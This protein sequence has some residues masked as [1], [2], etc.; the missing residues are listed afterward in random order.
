MQRIEIVRE[1]PPMQELPPMDS[2]HINPATG[3]D[4]LAYAGASIEQGAAVAAADRKPNDPSSWGKVGR[5][6]SCPFGSGKKYK[7]CHGR[8]D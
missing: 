5:N 3:E 1:P 2:H 7:H 8:F 6:E 4:E